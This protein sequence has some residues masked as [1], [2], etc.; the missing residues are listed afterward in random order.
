MGVVLMSIASFWPCGPSDLTGRRAQ[1]TE[2]GDPFAAAIARA[3]QRAADRADLRPAIRSAAL[4]FYETRSFA[5]AWPDAK[6]EALLE[7]LAGTYREGIDPGVYGLDALRE[8]V[9]QPRPI[10]ADA[11]A[12]LDVALT[13]AFLR[14]ALHFDGGAIDPAAAGIAWHIPRP[15]MDAAQLLEQALADGDVRGTLLGRLPAHDGYARLRSALA[16]YRALADQGGWPPQPGGTALRPK[17]QDRRVLALRRRL[18]LTGDLS[19]LTP[20]GDGSAVDASMFDGALESALQA[21]QERH[22]LDP[23]GVL[24]ARTRRAL[25]VPVSTRIGQLRMNLERWRWLPAHL[26][27]RY[28]LVDVAGYRVRIFEDGRE[29]LSLKAIIGK[30]Y[31]QTPVFMGKIEHLVFG[32]YWNV[33]RRIAVR[34]ILPAVQKQPGNFPRQGFVAFRSW[35]ADAP[36]IDPSRIAWEQLSPDHFP[37][38]IRQDPGPSNPLGQ[39]KFIFPNEFNVYLHDTPARQLFQERTR[40]FSSGCIRVAQPRELAVW[41]LRAA[42]EWTPDAIDAA[43]EQERDRDVILPQPVPVYLVYWTAW[44]EPD[45]QI[46]FRDDVYGRDLPLAEQLRLLSKPAN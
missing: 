35:A 43:L 18:E 34:D 41:L 11:A 45:G 2:S 33:P 28:V 27:E 3:L 26:G 44:V 13:I 25:D 7:I 14:C 19:P 4:R 16:R 15:P 5:P 8:Q 42:P 29:T 17:M 1:A 32:P 22:G 21:F 20:D 39:I 30:R 6:S 23:D 36:A 37:Y 9:S 46:R 24:G 40:T 31:R 38:R 12:D 10:P